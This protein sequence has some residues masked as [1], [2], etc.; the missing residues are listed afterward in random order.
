MHPQNSESE[1]PSSL[2]EMSWIC[3]GIAIGAAGVSMFLGSLSRQP[4]DPIQMFAA[5]LFLFGTCIGGGIGVLCG[6]VAALT[7]RS[8]SQ[9]HAAVLPLLSNA[10][11]V[12]AL[13]LLLK[14]FHPGPSLSDHP[15]SSL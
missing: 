8:W 3:L 13:T 7:S 1:K 9:L 10:F 5:L 4:F 2:C 14:V 11:A 12:V 15:A 6:V